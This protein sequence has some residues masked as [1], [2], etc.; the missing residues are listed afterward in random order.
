MEEKYIVINS[1]DRDWTNS[2]SSETPYNFRVV[3]GNN[4]R[5]GSSERNLNILVNETFKNIDY[6]SCQ[7]LVI[8]NRESVDKFRPSNNP[9]LLINI[10]NIEQ[11]SDSSNSK[12]QNAISIMTPKI[13]VSSS[14]TEDYR[15]LEFGNING[16][17][18]K[19]NRNLPYMDIQIQS[20]T[21]YTINGDNY[22][23][24]VLSVEQIYYNSSNT[25]LEVKTSDY[26]TSTDFQVGDTVKFDGYLFRDDGY[27]ESALFNN[28]INRNEG[29][30]IQSISQS[31]SSLDMYDI[32][33]I[34]PAG[35]FSR[36]TGNF[37]LLDWFDN[38]ITLTDIDSNIANDDTGKLINNN[39]Q[40]SIFFKVGV[41]NN[42]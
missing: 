7:N 14:S 26:F 34:L 17:N 33:N 2:N 24:D 40:T 3:F 37:E 12:L 11:V 5:Y 10:N 32:I 23:N 31:N 22:Q 41:I 28:Y 20:A 13:P 15:Y 21:G 6:L 29:H 19:V 9:Y 4:S 27:Y 18:K 8:S 42:H 35:E 30:I 25:I 16:Q 36:S 39:L 38:L 1:G